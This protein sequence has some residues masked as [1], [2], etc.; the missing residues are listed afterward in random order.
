MDS[1]G[2]GWLSEGNDR[3]HSGTTARPRE[4][5]T[6]RE[7]NDEWNLNLYPIVPRARGGAPLGWPVMRHDDGKIRPIAS[8][9]LC[10]SWFLTV[11]TSISSTSDAID[12]DSLSRTLSS[13][14]TSLCSEGMEWVTIMILSLISFSLTGVSPCHNLVRSQGSPEMKDMIAGHQSNK[15]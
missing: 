2:T 13:P 6:D 8:D 5:H 7:R 11:T 9:S 3:F 1:A 10:H 14:P 15:C 12:R 4:Q